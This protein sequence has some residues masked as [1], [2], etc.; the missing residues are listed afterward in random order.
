MKATGWVDFILRVADES[1]TGSSENLERLAVQ[2][3]MDDKAKQALR[4]RGYGWT[5]IDLLKTAE[6]VENVTC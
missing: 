5:G 6:M 2:L 1:R 4:N 3:E